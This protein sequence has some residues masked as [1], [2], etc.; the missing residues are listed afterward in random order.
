VAITDKHTTL[1]R[2]ALI[3]NPNVG[4]T[5]IFNLLTGMR[6]KVGNYPGVTVEKKTGQ[7]AGDPP[8]EIIDLPGSYSLSPK[9]LD[10]RIA[11][12]VL[13]GHLT[14]EPPP[15]LVVCIVDAS[16]LER[17]LYL[18]TQVLDLGIPV[19]VGLNM[20][21][22]AEEA[23]LSID[24]AQLSQRLGV[25]VLPMSASKN[26]GIG[27]LKFQIRKETLAAP[28]E[29][30]WVLMPAVE[31]EVPELMDVLAREVPSVPERQRFIE[32]LQCLT[33]DTMLDYWTKWAPGFQ[34]AVQ[35]VRDRLEENKVPFQQAEV[36]GRYGWLSPLVAQV[37]SRKKGPGTA[38]V[39]DRIDAVLTHRV[40]GPLFFALL[41][42]LI[43]QA[44]FSWATPAMDAIENG[45]VLLGAFVRDVFP[46][47]MATDLLVDGVV[48]GV[49]NVVVFLPQIL[50]LFFFLGLMEDTGYMARSAFIMDRLM[51]RVGLGGGSVVP[52][53]SSFA[54]AI[55]GIMAA[56]TLANPR[57]RLITIMVAPL[58]SCSARLPVY[59]LFIAAFLP[60]GSV[61]GLITFQGLAMFSMYLLGTVMAFIASFVLKK[62]V[63]KGESSFFAM[64]LPPYRMPRFKQIFWRMIDRS[65]AFVIRAGKIIF[66]MSII[67]WGLARFPASDPTPELMASRAAADAVYEMK[68]DSLAG[69]GTERSLAMEMVTEDMSTTFRRLDAAE[70]GH[71]IEHS[72]IGMIGHTLEPV[73]RPLGFDW[74]ISAGIVSAFA[75]REVIIS[76]LATIYSVGDVDEDSPLLREKLKADRYPN[77]DPV[78]TPLVAVSLLVFFVL[79]LQCMSTLAIA[80][81]ETNT[82]K[83]PAVMWLYMTGLAYLFSLIIYQ[84]GTALGWG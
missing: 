53:L 79:A 25:P 3:G 64:E 38:S 82:W 56:R 45:V 35:K 74:K 21:D 22:A 11:Y 1:R 33:S 32:V 84:G 19:I 34:E 66:G 52:L 48:T 15:D 71:R 80:R 2:V 43:F 7:M 46:A 51:S 10:E 12:D 23:G 65:K 61:L 69:M 81:R 36:I 57:D 62:I 9:S 30:S 67:L 54:C 75:A 63:F 73:M 55:P 13:S 68:V 49:G 83:W 37:V 76:A 24:V 18:V 28:P 41:L 60:T 8:V 16:N 26:D 42:L 5:T 78:Y 31:V 27:K 20:M 6:Q 4:K 14:S 77:G 40:F 44:V 59:T 47:G 17:N 72:F 58:M 70:A 29:R 50:L 39:S